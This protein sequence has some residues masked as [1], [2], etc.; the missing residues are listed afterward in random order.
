MKIFLI[1][2]ILFLGSCSSSRSAMERKSLMMPKSYEQ[3]R[4]K[5]L[6][7]KYKELKKGQKLY[8]KNYKKR[9]PKKS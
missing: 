1:I 4:N 2:L 8:K 7:D 9:T 3:P 6:Y 5:K